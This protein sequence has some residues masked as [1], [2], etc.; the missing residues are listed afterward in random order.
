MIDMK[1]ADAATLQAE[2]ILGTPAPPPQ[3]QTRSLPQAAPA[4]TTRP[5]RRSSSTLYDLFG[6]TVATIF[7]LGVNA[8]LWWFGA[9]FTL[10]WLGIDPK[11]TTWM[12]LAWYG[13]P[14]GITLTESHF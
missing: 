12:H 8:V 1:A 5:R 4:T 3:T 7:G 10:I 9:A 11:P 13:I 2:L 6:Q 14:L